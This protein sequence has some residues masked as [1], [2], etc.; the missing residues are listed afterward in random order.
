MRAVLLGLGAAAIL[1]PAAPATAERWSDPNFVAAANVT[2][3]RAGPRNSTGNF[4]GERKFRQGKAG[5]R[6][7][8]RHR[9]HRDRDGDFEGA[10][11]VG[12]GWDGEWQGDSA[13]RADSFND[14]WHE[15]PHR[16][17]PRWMANN[18]GCQRMW[19]GGGDWR[20]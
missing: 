3:H 10:V 20:C 11:F 2:V 8:E 1:T 12:G 5:H 14:W 16:A 15:R 6:D 19:W 13:W 9:R 17:F 7:R 18:D 4:A